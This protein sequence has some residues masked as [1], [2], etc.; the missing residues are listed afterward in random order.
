M[1]RVLASLAAA[2]ALASPV[3]ADDCPDKTA[4]RA[5]F[6]LERAGTASEVRPV[7][8]LFT[9]VRN[10]YPSGKTQDVLYFRGLFDVS[11]RDESAH[12]LSV[13]L[14]DLRTLFPLDVGA[15]RA[16]T[17][18]LA[19]PGKAGPPLSLELTVAGR[20]TFRMG[21]CRY[22]VLVVRNRTLNV[23]GKV[24]SQY[25]D[26]YAPDLGIVLGRRF[27]DGGGRQTSVLFESI[28]LLPRPSPRRRPPVRGSRSVRSASRSR[29]RRSEP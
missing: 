2:V 15:R 26:L 27:D 18:V 13:P 6:V 4:A 11:R 3:A 22:D 9:H 25:T 5:G 12:R 20:E 24:T 28:R 7:S 17:F 1:L 29:S 14:T 21:A 8:D 23:A 16:V 19:E 10:T